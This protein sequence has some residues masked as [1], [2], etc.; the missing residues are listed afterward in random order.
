M[1]GAMPQFFYPRLKDMMSFNLMN[2]KVDGG[3]THVEAQNT[4][5]D[6]YQ[7]WSWV[8]F[9]LRSVCARDCCQRRTLT[10]FGWKAREPQWTVPI[11]NLPPS[12]VLVCEIPCLSG[13]RTGWHPPSHSTPPSHV[14]RLESK[15]SSCSCRTATGTATASQS[16]S[17]ACTRCSFL[18]LCDHAVA[19]ATGTGTA[20]A[21]GTELALN[22]T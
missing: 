15:L 13:E 8:L 7:V 12:K 2:P 18:Q 3:K 4:Y 5:Y 19:T 1:P 20:T 10:Q 16:C 14:T 11:G 9:I 21:T 22:Q 6:T 17:C